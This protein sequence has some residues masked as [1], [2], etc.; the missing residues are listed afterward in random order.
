MAETPKQILL[1]SRGA[2]RRDEGRCGA[3]NIKPGMLLAY[4][5]D[6]LLVPHASAGGYAEKMVADIDSLRGLTIDDE[7]ES[8]DVVFVLRLAPGDVVYGLIDNGVDMDIEDFMSSSGDGSV[9]V[10]TST[11]V[12]LFAVEEAADNSGGSSHARG[13]LRAL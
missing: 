4:G 12:R 7:Y 13:K 1:K 6:G 5:T 11:D 2:T 8:G 9:K 10:A 3:T